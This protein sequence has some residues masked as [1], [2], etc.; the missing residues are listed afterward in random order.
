M[1]LSILLKKKNKTALAAATAKQE[2]IYKKLTDYYEDYGYC[3]VG[4]EY[5]KPA[6]LEILYDLIRKG[7]ATTPGDAINIYLADLEQA[8]M[9]RLQEEATAAAKETAKNTKQA[10]KSAKKAARYSSA[11]FWFK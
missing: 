8:E 4:M 2:N 1:A 5:T 7:R 3:S 11:S 9:R 10:A 6:T